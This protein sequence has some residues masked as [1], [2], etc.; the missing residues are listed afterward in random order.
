[1]GKTDKSISIIIP[2]YNEEQTIKRVIKNI[3]KLDLKNMEIIVVDDG[4]TDRTFEAASNLGVKIVRHPY[5][6]GNG[7]AI[8]TGIRHATGDVLVMMDA[9]SQ[10][11]PEDIP[12]LIDDMEQYDMVIGARNLNHVSFNHRNIANQVYNLLATYLTGMKIQDLTSGYRAIKREV[13]CRFVSMLPNGFSYPT[14]LTLGLVK[15]GFSIKFIPIKASKRVGKSKIKLGRDGTKFFLTIIKIASLYSPLKVFLP[16][17]FVFFL[18][19]L[20]NYAYTFLTEHRF[21]NMTA[22]LLSTSV[23]IFMMGF[24]AEQIAQLR[25]DRIQEKDEQK[26]SANVTDERTNE[27]TTARTSLVRY[28]R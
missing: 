25:Y 6:K 21:T 16:V 26:Y 8:K 17:S 13:A 18:L 22:L 2:S 15:N 12:R 19:G 23:I 4:S 3:Q 14:T 10:H 20:L 9:D 28:S 27:S 24:V 5:N 7:A 11:N 1:M